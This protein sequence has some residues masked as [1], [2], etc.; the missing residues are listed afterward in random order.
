MKLNELLTKIPTKNEVR[1]A[2]YITDKTYACKPVPI[3]LENRYYH[4]NYRECEVYKVD[5]TK[6]FGRMEVYILL[7]EEK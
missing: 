4:R 5:F 3:I 6:Q 7:N 2:D 1:I